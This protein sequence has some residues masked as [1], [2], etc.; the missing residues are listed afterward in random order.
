MSWRAEMELRVHR[1]PAFPGIVGGFPFTVTKTIKGQEERPSG[2]VAVIDLRTMWHQR[3]KQDQVPGLSQYRF[4]IDPSLNLRGK[5]PFV[6]VRQD[7]RGII[8]LLVLNEIG[9]FGK[10]ILGELNTTI[11]HR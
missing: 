6:V 11:F 10:V 1:I 2:A 4:P 7:H 5:I 9:E 8:V 3:I